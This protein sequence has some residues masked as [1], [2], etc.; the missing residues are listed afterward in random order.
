MPRNLNTSLKP[1]RRSH[2]PMDAYDRLPSDIRAWLREAHLPWSAQSVLKLWTK[3]LRTYRGDRAA[4]LA[5]LTECELR[6][7]K[8]DA[9]QIWGTSYPMSDLSLSA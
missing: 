6:K 7:L 8:K 2:R 5:Y 9:P 3:A 1:S 4:A